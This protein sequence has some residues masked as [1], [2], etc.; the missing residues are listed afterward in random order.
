M[1]FAEAFLRAMAVLVGASPCALVI[2]TPSAVLAGIA[3]A[4]RSGVLIKGGMHLES[5]GTVRAIAFDKTGTVTQGRPEVTD[6]V[7][8]EG[9]TEQDVLAIAFALDQHS[10]HPLALAVVR[11]AKND[12]VSA[13][14]IQAIRAI[15]GRGV[16]GIIA[17]ERALIAGP[18]AFGR[19][20]N[21]EI[22]NALR[23]RIEKLEAQARTVS[24]ISIGE[25]VVGAIAMADQV[26][27][28]VARIFA[29]L[30]SLGIR[31]L[32]MLTGDNAT[33]ASVIAKPLGIDEV[34]AELLP[35][36]KI[37]EVRALMQTW[38]SVA[39]VGDGVNDAPALATATVGIAMGATGTD[40]AL[41]AADVALMADDLS[42]LPFAVGLSRRARRTIMQN[43]VISLGVVGMLIP[44]TVTGVVPLS[45]A[46]VLHE[47]STVVVAFNALRLLRYRDQP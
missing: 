18:R 11:R 3:Q 6:V 2:S 16:E 13:P 31:R 5:L 43:V 7:A 27:P 39:M 45:W 47:G 15:P 12:S 40:V 33:V 22:P 34:K 19:D 30:K 41:E 29:K 32:I 9:S 25:R 14:E 37:V 23:E 35:E 21:P 26:R 20:K 10:S 4:A 42:K 46:V 24:V 28:D 36:N 17:N 38:G 8:D 1:T 44:F